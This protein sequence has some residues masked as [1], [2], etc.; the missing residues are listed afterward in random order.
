MRTLR[1]R[2]LICG[3]HASPVVSNIAESIASRGDL[4]AQITN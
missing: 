4:P 1:I 2:T 3:R